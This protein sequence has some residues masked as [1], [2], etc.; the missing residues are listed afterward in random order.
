MRL[1]AGLTRR[2]QN[3]DNIIAAATAAFRPTTLLF[4]VCRN[5]RQKDSRAVEPRALLNGHE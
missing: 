5:Y 2:N 4:C 1:D 3:N